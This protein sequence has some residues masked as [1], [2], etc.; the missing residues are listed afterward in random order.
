M[1]SSTMEFFNR[2]MAAR[3]RR[4]AQ[5]AALEAVRSFPLTAERKSH[6]L[7]APLIVSLTSYAKRFKTLANTIKSL[8]DQDIHIDKIILWVG[9]DDYDLLPAEVRSLE[10][11]L[12]ETFSTKD[13]RSYTKLIPALRNFPDAYIVTADDDIYYPTDWVSTILNGYVPGRRMTVC[14][15]AHM[16]QV[17][18]SG[19][20]TAY[21]SWP[22]AVSDRADPGAG[23][24]LFPTG[25]GGI[26]YPPST[27]NEEVLNEA[28]FT[29]LCPYADDI[30]FFWMQLINE[31][32]RRRVGS[33]EKFITWPSSQEAGLLNDNLHLG[34][35]DSQLIALERR[36]G[37]LVSFIGHTDSGSG[38]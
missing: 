21:A 25:V 30:W 13:I 17:D 32:D 14:R 6:S 33:V 1:L 34:R 38:K 10:G 37:K 27:F 26:L 23:R 8:L 9:A 15:R 12:F 18:A 3:R 20:T 7:G 5:R 19:A 35:N 22:H 31:V 29:D 16:A 11:A 36:Y 2:K 24:A 28:V 4:A